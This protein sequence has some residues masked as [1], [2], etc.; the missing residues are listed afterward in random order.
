MMVREMLFVNDRIADYDPSDAVINMEQ[1][2]CNIGISCK[3]TI[4]KRV[5]QVNKML[6]IRRG[7]YIQYSTEYDIRLPPY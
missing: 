4:K 1:T 2:D 3:Q 7:A 5:K 6:Y